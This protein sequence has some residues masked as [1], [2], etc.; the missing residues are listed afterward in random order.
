MGY[1]ATAAEGPQVGDGEASVAPAPATCLKISVFH[2]GRPV[3][4][5][6]FPA[7]AI[8]NLVDL[9][10]DEVR[11]RVAAHALDLEEL[12]ARCASQG[13]PPGELFTLIGKVDTVRA[14]ME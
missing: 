4:Q 2:D 7:Y 14:W 3:V 1:R 8:V 6:S 12:A 13:C 11:P 10:P 5:V 9:V